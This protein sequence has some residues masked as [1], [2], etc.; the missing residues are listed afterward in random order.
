MLAGSF[1]DAE[2][3]RAKT[4]LKAQTIFARDG[5]TSMARIMGTLR[6]CGLDASYFTRWPDM[7]DAVNAQQ[8]SEV[9][10]ESLQL[11][12]SV[13]SYLLPVETKAGDSAPDADSKTLKGRRS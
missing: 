3:S 13:T 11:N 10:K 7:I 2:L 6:L 1:T 4:L 12:R 5:L 9:A 8:V